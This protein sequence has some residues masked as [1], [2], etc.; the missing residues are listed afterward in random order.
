VHKIPGTPPET[1]MVFSVRSLNEKYAIVRLSGDQN[2]ARPTSVP[3]STL[4]QPS[5]SFACVFSYFSTRNQAVL[6]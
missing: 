5:C 3:V 4:T 6:I 1:A 2:G